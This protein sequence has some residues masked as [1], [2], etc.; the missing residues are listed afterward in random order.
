MLRSATYWT[1]GA[2]DTRVTDEVSARRKQ[3]GIVVAHTKRRSHLLEICPGELRAN[4][5]HVQKDGLDSSE[6]HA[7]VDMLELR[8]NPLTDVL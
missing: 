4:V 6:H 7:G 5:L 2:E 8:N 3:A 1:S